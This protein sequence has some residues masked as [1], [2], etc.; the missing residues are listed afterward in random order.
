MARLTKRLGSLGYS[1]SKQRALA[2]MAR[3]GQ[4]ERR[5][6]VFT[7]GKTGNK[8]VAQA[9]R[10]ALGTRVFRIHRLTPATVTA[11]EAR[12]RTAH[13]AARP[14]HLWESQYLLSRLPRPTAPWDVV[15]M[16]RDPITQAVAAF[17]QSRLR[18]TD[19][20]SDGSI[21]SLARSFPNHHAYRN[22]LRWFD[23]EFEP[24]LGIDVYEHPFD[25]HRAYGVIE[26][27]AVRVLVLRT[28]S[29]H[30]APEALAEFFGLVE[31]VPLPSDSV[32]SEDATGGMYGEF[33]REIS[34]PAELLE[35][36]YDSRYARHFYA[37]AERARFRSAWEQRHPSGE[38]ETRVSEDLG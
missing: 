4:P 26:T 30:V 6:V 28:E 21:E 32:S 33:L 10:E 38:V 16:V 24:S 2:R 29:L 17:F 14:I 3:E 11:A 12:Y 36:A 27:P 22:P 7:M 8:S 9:L 35:R 31:P 13:S 37:P 25:P 19:S 34:M 20:G 23:R 5:V 15:T 18:V 1:I